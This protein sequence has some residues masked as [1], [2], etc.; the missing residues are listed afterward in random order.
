[1]RVESTAK[2]AEIE[3][4][5]KLKMKQKVERILA[6]HPSCFINRQLIY[7]YPEQLF[8][9]A[10]VMA[11]EHADFEGG[12]FN[13]VVISDIFISCSTLYVATLE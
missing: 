4:A 9:Q 7:N 11:I 12:T 8:A 1:M 2:I 6:H 10:G 3:E 5:E 13:V